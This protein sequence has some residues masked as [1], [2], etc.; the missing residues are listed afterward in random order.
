MKSFEDWL[1]ESPLAPPAQGTWQY[2][3]DQGHGLLE[4][5]GK[6]MVTCKCCDHDFA[7]SDFCNPEEFDPENQDDF[8]CGRSDRCCP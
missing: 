1:Q 5:G 3:E 4:D 7:I 2:W 8:Y 6:F